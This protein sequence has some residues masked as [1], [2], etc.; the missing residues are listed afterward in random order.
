MLNFYFTIILVIFFIFTHSWFYYTYTYKSSFS[1]LSDVYYRVYIDDF[2]FNN[3]YYLWTNFWLIPNVLVTITLLYLIYFMDILPKQLMYLLVFV[4]FLFGEIFDYWYLNTQYNFNIVN[5]EDVNVL[6]LNN[7][8]KYHPLILYVS[9]VAGYS[10]VT[11][12][13]FKYLP[14]FYNVV[15]RLTYIKIMK[16]HLLLIFFTLLLGSWWAVQEGSWG[17]WWNWDASEVFGLLIA[18]YL[19]YYMHNSTNLTHSY[20]VKL[21]SGLLLCG[22]AAGYTL[23]QI[24]FNL[25]SHNF[26]TSTLTNLALLQSFTVFFLSLLVK[27]VY[28]VLMAIQ[29]LSQFIVL[30]ITVIF[31]YTRSVVK[32]FVYSL[33]VLLI[34]EISVSFS[35][36]INEFCFELL[37]SNIF[38]IDCGV[39]T[40][41]TWTLLWL[42]IFFLQLRNYLGIVLLYA[43]LTLLPVYTIMTLV[44]TVYTMYHSLH[45]YLVVF[46]SLNFIVVG[47]NDQFWSFVPLTYTLD[48]SGGS[49]WLGYEFIS[50]LN[51]VIELSLVSLT[52]NY[53]VLTPTKFFLK[54]TSAEGNLFLLG[55]SFWN[56]LQTL[57]LYRYSYRIAVNILDTSLLALLTT[58]ATL[59]CLSYHFF[60]RRRLMV[61]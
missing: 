17:G 57:L 38:Y 41:T 14:L 33:I 50:V 12:S 13:Q 27:C 19:V 25:I 35:P 7:I 48:L 10:L 49:L 32:V 11:P 58:Y 43:G 54:S 56:S 40:A 15:I 53:V 22:A 60:Y 59:N 4:S 2:F 47:K 39:E 52:N 36:L 28:A 16:L 1:D 29:H 18:L 24:N 42:C 34:I 45:L 23:I 61:F 26:N 37:N 9:V 31:F 44:L 46:V 8:N 21:L 20:L 6:L 51:S 3:Y 5:S 30:N 55:S